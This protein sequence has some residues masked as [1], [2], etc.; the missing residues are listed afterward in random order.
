MLFARK[1]RK[2][3]RK[4]NVLVVGAP[5][6][7]TTLVAGLLSAGSDASPML[8]ECTCITQII[9]HFHRVLHYSDPQRFA[10]YAINESTLAGNYRAMVDSMLATVRSHFDK[11]N[12]RY[13]ILK[14]PE[15]THFVDLIPNFFG[16]DSKIICVV[17]DPRAVIASALEVEH[18]KSEAAWGALESA[19]AGTGADEL[20][21]QL[22]RERRVA[23]DFFLYYWKVQQSELF[24]QGRIHIVHY[25]KIVA[26]EESEFVR[27]E[28]F[29][30]FSVGREGFGKVH[31]D[32]D[33]ADPTHS[34][35]YGGSINASGSDYRKKLTERQ[36]Q[37]I[38]TMFSGMNEIYGWW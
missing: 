33:I 19:P 10:A 30:G 28:E 14:D 13:L 5:R 16:D 23:S 34:A 4:T 20:I 9:E 35:G 38:E 22:F 3:L 18:K 36:V 32:F 21:T 15:L 26:R 6:S 27:L 37:H 29:L 7:G 2:A 8:P 11:L 17:R 1:K 12:Y 25:E 31:F 24:R